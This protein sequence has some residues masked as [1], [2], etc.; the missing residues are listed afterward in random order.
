MKK[1]RFLRKRGH[2]YYRTGSFICSPSLFPFPSLF[3][4]ADL[5]PLVIITLIIGYTDHDHNYFTSVT[6]FT[7]A[8]ISI[9]PLSYF[10][11]MGIAR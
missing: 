1:K 11:G 10:I 3:S 4:P 7:T 6:K 8:I 2:N 5:L 9:I